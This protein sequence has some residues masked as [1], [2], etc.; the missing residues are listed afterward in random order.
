M[1]DVEMWAIKDK[2]LDKLVITKWGRML[3]KRKTHPTQVNV[4]GYWEHKWENGKK[5]ECPKFKRLK[6]V[7]V[8]VQEIT[9]D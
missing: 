8:R 6:P 4:V 5:V 7:R 2:E 1:I 3:W 9:N